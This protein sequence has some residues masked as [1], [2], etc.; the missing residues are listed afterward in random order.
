[1]IAQA[2]LGD[3]LA[4]LTDQLN[5]WKQ[6]YGAVFMSTDIDDATRQDHETAGTHMDIGVDDA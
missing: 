6:K 4:R 5:E 2:D 1:M 3:E